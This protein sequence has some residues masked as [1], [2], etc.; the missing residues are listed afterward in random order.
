MHKSIQATAKNGW[1]L[2]RTLRSIPSWNLC[3]RIWLQNFERCYSTT[4][5][6][7]VPIESIDCVKVIPGVAQDNID[8]HKS[9]A[10]TIKQNV[11]E[12]R[13]PLRL[14]GLASQWIPLPTMWGSME[15]LKI[16]DLAN[17]PITVGNSVSSSFDYVNKDGDI[18]LAALNDDVPL[19]TFVSTLMQESAQLQRGIQPRERSYAGESYRSEVVGRILSDLEMPEWWRHT[20]GGLDHWC[21]PFFR[22]ADETALDHGKITKSLLWMSAGDTV[23][24]A[25]RDLFHN[26]HVVLAGTKTFYLVDPK[27][28]KEVKD[29]VRPVV[30]QVRCENTLA[31]TT[32]PYLDGDGH[33][34]QHAGHSAVDFK[35]SHTG[36]L[37]KQHSFAN[38]DVTVYECTLE[39]GDVLYM[40]H[41]WYHEV[42]S[43]ANDEGFSMTLNFWQ[44]SLW[45]WSLT[46]DRDH[47]DREV[48]IRS[49]LGTSGGGGRFAAAPWETFLD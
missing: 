43:T 21:Q 2:K 24:R 31:Y 17:T 44:E 29:M 8:T 39:P 1:R 33:Q 19:G 42:H 38:N 45:G 6:P 28:H 4:T 16:G 18:E 23:A 10:H 47:A 40:P 34:H 46:D 15:Q 11:L 20:G 9:I 12:N 13:Q 26:F 3:S 41:D 35:L 37:S 22:Q 48:L 7:F 27:H 14:R 36:T 32:T 5:N 25:H 30:R 49:A